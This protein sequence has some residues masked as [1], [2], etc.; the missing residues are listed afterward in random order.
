V[1][2]AA[3][4]GPIDWSGSVISS[5]SNGG[6]QCVEAVKGPDSAVYVRNSKDPRGNV[7]RFTSG[8]WGAFLAGARGGEF[9]QLAG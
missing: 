4:Y 3:G 9:D 5:H 8:E 2:T 6:A 1:S 7:V